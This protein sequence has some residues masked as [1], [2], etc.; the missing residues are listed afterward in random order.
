MNR[1]ITPLWLA[2]VSILSLLVAALIAADDV[3]LMKRQPNTDQFQQLVGGLGFGPATD[4][5]HCA[6]T[7]DPRFVDE[8]DYDVGPVAGHKCFCPYHTGTVF[9]HPPIQ[10]V[11]AEARVGDDANLP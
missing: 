2:S 1:M 11:E 3:R 6:H 8:C 7:F 4:W 5:S 9:S 10:H